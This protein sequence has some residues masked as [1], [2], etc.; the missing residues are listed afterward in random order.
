MIASAYINRMASIHPDGYDE[1]QPYLKAAEPDYKEIIQS[2]S[3]RRRMSRVVKMGVACGLQCIGS[4]PQEEIHAIITATG[5]G[6]L[7][8]TE[9]FMNTLL[10]NQEQFLNPTPFIQSTF[11]TIGAQIALLCQ[12]QAY[13]M[14]YA[15][16]GFSFES[17]LLDGLL[18]LQEGD[19]NVL[20]G[21][22]DEITET[23]FLIQ[24]RMGLFRNIKAGEGAQFF[25]IS[26]EEKENSLARIYLPST[27]VVD[28]QADK[29]S[30]IDR[31]IKEYLMANQVDPEQETV[32]LC[33][34][35]KNTCGEYPTAS[36]FGVYAAVGKLQNEPNKARHILVLNCHNH[37][38]Y[39]LILLSSV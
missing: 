2:P 35:F 37:T 19:K 12:N 9:K 34:D 4:T 20:V 15:H 3:L 16:R 18:R 6:C 38:H 36:A 17:A 13:N 28:D 23:S 10:D 32:M 25:L 30:A 1:T 31:R 14:T 7:T 39:S 22:F 26:Q 8:D 33:N 24:Q 27:F 21:A 11:N 29:D 5:L